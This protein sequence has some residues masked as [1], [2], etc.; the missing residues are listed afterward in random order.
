MSREKALYNKNKEVKLRTRMMSKEK[1]R[2]TNIMCTLI[3]CVWGPKQQLVGGKNTAHNNGSWLFLLWWYWYLWCETVVSHEHAGIWIGEIGGTSV[4]TGEMVLGIEKK[5][6][7]NLVGDLPVLAQVGHFSTHGFISFHLLIQLSL[8]LASLAT[9]SGQLLFSFV[10][11]P[12]Q[13][14]NSVV[15]FVNLAT[16]TLN[17]ILSSQLSNKHH[18]LTQ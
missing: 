12:L 3:M 1:H 7:Q 18:H 11:L 17:K 8:Q 9:S 2:E 5:T 6:P 13:G 16:A 4:R 15:D 10:Q 14:F